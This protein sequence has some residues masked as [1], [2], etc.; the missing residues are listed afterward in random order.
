MAITAKQEAF[1]VNYFIMRN[2]TQAAIKAGYS[3]HLINNHATHLLQNATIKARLAELQSHVSLTAKQAT[4]YVE[5]RLKLLTEIAR[6]NI[7]MPVSAGHK[8]TAIAE[9]NKMGGDYAPEK[10]R[11]VA[12]VNVVFVIGKGYRDAPQLEEGLTG[13]SNTT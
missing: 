1:A 13:S 5:E 11:P 2:A 7:E 4:A 12:Q 10:T 8:I 3:P 9:M 6:H